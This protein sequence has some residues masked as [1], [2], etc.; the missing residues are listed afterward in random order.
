[1]T[2]SFGRWL[3]WV[4][5]AGLALQ[6]FFVLRIALMV[7]VDPQSTAFMRSEAWRVAGQS[8]TQAD[9]SWRWSSQ[10]VDY[11]E[12]SPHLKRAVMASEDAGFVEHGGVDWDAIQSAWSKNERRQELVEKRTEQL[13]KRLA[14]KPEAVEAAIKAIKPP[15]I[16]GGSTITQQLA[17]NLL[18]SGER[19]LLRKGQELMLTLTLEALL[20]KE[21][22]LEIYLN[23][24]EWGEGVFGA[25]AAS[26]RYFKKPAAKLSPHEAARLAVMLPSPKFFETRPGSAY[27]AR[28]TS[29]IVAR[30]GDVQAP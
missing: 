25:E 19:N 12:I 13:E 10:W 28:R 18:L 26:Q 9:K 2:K 11:A 6:L 17:K 20:S 22:I 15:K 7:V 8:I 30:M 14:K 24:V 27:L 5:L 23:S 1:M 29:T 4:L 21:R 3:L 16:L